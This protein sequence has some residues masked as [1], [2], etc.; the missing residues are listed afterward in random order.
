MLQIDSKECLADARSAIM[1]DHGSCSI[2][3]T[4]SSLE[5]QKSH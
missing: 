4:D 2:T 3:L 5:Q 1:F